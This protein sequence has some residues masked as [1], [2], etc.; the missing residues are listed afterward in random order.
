ME[1]RTKQITIIASPAT[2]NINVDKVSAGTEPVYRSINFIGTHVLLGV[3]TI[4]PVGT[5][6]LDMTFMIFWNANVTSAGANVVNIFGQ[7][8]PHTVAA[9]NGIFIVKWNGASWDVFVLVDRMTVI[10]LA[11]IENIGANK[12]IMGDKITG[13]PTAVASTGDVIIDGDGIATIQALQVVDAMIFDLDASKLTGILDPLLITDRTAPVA[14]LI[15]ISLLDALIVQQASP[16]SVVETSKYSY[17]IPANYLA[18]NGEGVK[19]TLSGEFAANANVKTL[20]VKLDGNTILTNN[21]TAS[22]QGR[23]RVEAISLRSGAGS[24]LSDSELRIEA[25]ASDFQ[26]DKSLIDWTTD[27]VLSVTVEE[28]AGVGNEILLDQI[29]LETLR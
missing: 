16:A 3:L 28:A 17:N 20:R 13:I 9:K 23:F 29:I 22:P 7:T 25:V 21:N 4:A 27:T 10:P 14:K 2:I 24:S 15:N 12:M 19:L 5:P 11:E 1:D 18:N 8:L 6:R 26:A